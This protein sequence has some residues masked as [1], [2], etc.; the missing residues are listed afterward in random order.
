M[1]GQTHEALADVAI[2]RHQEIAQID[3]TGQF[4]VFA[5]D[6]D[7]LSQALSRMPQPAQCVGRVILELQRHD[8]GI[9]DRADHGLR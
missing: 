9:D 2:A 8:V 5:Q 3:D 6:R 7:C 4:T 1:Y